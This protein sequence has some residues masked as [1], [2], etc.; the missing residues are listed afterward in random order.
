MSKRQVNSK[1]TAAIERLLAAQDVLTSGDVARAGHV[2]RQAAHYQ[3][4]AMVKRGDLAHEGAGRGSHFRRLAL[5]AYHY[6]L[7]GLTEDEVWFEEKTEIGRRD[8]KI[9]DNPNIMPLLNF[10]FTEMVNNAIDHSRGTNLKV[11]WYVH[12]DYLAFDV[13]DDGIGAFKNMALDRGLANE[14][15]SIGEIAKGKQ[16]SAP[17]AHSGLGIFFTSR[18]ANRFELTSGRLSWIVDN[19]RQDV[20]V[21]WLERPRVGTLVRC[22]FDADTTTKAIEAFDTM[23]IPDAPGVHRSTI[24]VSLFQNGDTFVSRSEAK[25]LAANLESFGKVEID[26]AGVRQIG[27]GFIDEL[28]RVWQSDHPETL[29]IATNT[30]PAIDALLRLTS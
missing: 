25:R 20:A 27:Q 16:T 28:F 1:V 24:R 5:L 26:F 6:N 12:E 7:N 29:L 23:S 14:F 15:D 22:E 19:R 11:R 30:N 9:L 8:L 4:S 17:H 13:A 21:E 2:S 3:L 10:T 18:M